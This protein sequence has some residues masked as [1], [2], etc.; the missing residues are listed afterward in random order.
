MHVL[1]MILTAA[2][3]SLLL[4]ALCCCQCWHFPT[5]KVCFGCPRFGLGLISFKSIW[6]GYDCPSVSFRSGL[7]WVFFFARQVWYVSDWVQMFTPVKKAI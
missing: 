4:I 2:A 5:F 7:F 1:L 3:C 6:V